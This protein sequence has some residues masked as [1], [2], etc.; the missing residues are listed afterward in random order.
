MELKSESSSVTTS[1][2]PPQK[3]SGRWSVGASLAAEEFDNDRLHVRLIETAK[4]PTDPES[5][6]PKAWRI[7]EGSRDFISVG[8]SNLSKAAL[9]SGVEWNLLST[10]TASEPSHLQFSAEFQ[11]LWQVA[12]PL[13][14]ALVESYAESAAKYRQEHFLPEADDVQEIPEPRPWQVEALASLARVREAGHSRA[15]VAVATG[16][17]K[18]WLAAFDACQFGEEIGQ[19]PK[20]SDH[21]PSG[22]YSCPGRSGPVA[23]ARSPV[24][25]QLN[26][27]VYRQSK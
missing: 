11:A 25:G 9:V 8:S 23:S 12:S 18:T 13:T 20:G 15:L 22:S 16:M 17:G 2:S 26:R 3:H 21:C 10:S 24:R 6:H 7:V 4:L 19:T 14:P 27:V 1:T 5:F